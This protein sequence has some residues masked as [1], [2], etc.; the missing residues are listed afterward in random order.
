VATAVVQFAS[1]VNTTGTTAT[2]TFASAVTK[3]NLVVL[4]YS[5]GTLVNPTSANQETWNL[6]V[7]VQTAATVGA[8]GYAYAFNVT[9]GWTVCTLTWAAANG[10]CHFVAWEVSG[11]LYLDQILNT[12][13]ISGN[14]ATTM[15]GPT[16]TPSVG[17]GIFIVGSNNNGV[18][19]NA[20]TGGYTDDSRAANAWA[21]LVSTD[22]LSHTCQW[23]KGAGDYL[24]GQLN[25]LLP[26][27]APR[28]LTPLLPQQL[29]TLP[30]VPPETVG[31]PPAAPVVPTFAPQQAPLVLRPTYPAILQV[32]QPQTIPP[33]PAPPAIV[34]APSSSLVR[35]LLPQL[36]LI[37]LPEPILP[38]TPAAPKFIEPMPTKAES[39]SDEY[40]SNI[41][42]LL[43]D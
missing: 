1:H 12:S 16:T 25:F 8:N 29:P 36:R 7:G 13:V 34:F 9:G 5:W 33:P 26:N 31:P 18:A 19:N 27:A 42:R 11:A 35:Q 17:R 15:T 3:G 4:G 2:T 40:P 43:G 21:H 37:P 39:P 30:Y 6:N 23:I 28:A 24:T 22:D 38:P 32:I 41:I 20:P 10:T 14:T